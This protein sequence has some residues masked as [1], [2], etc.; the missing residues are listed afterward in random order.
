[1]LYFVN[2]SAAFIMLFITVGTYLNINNNIYAI[3]YFLKYSRCR[4]QFFVLSYIALLGVPPFS[5]FAPKFAALSSSWSFGGGFLFM[6]ALLSVFTSFALYLQV[7]DI[8]FKTKLSRSQ[9]IKHSTAS[10]M[11]HETAF[12][13]SD[14]LV[15]LFLAIF[16]ILGFLVFKDTFFIFNVF[17]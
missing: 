9:L 8:L 16:C 6:S 10:F 7:F 12:C 15:L 5:L 3:T 4:Y 2:Y 11:K 14:A 1:M 13:Y 17:L